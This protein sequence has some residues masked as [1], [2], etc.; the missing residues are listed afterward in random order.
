M[1]C[2]GVA[3]RTS[4]AG[5]VA[6]FRTPKEPP[7]PVTFTHVPF[8]LRLLAGFPGLSGVFLDLPFRPMPAH[9]TAWLVTL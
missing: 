8:L 7:R 4:R 9:P 2:R 6:W 3:G 1:A 5:S